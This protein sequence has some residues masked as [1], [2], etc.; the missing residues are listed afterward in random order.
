[1]NYFS[2]VDTDL[3]LKSS[4]IIHEMTTRDIAQRMAMSFEFAPSFL[5]IMDTLPDC[6]DTPKLRHWVSV[7]RSL[8]RSKLQTL[9]PDPRFVAHFFID[10]L[11]P[12]RVHEI[13][14]FR[15]L[16]IALE[17]AIHRGQDFEWHDETILCPPTFNVW[18]HGTA[19]SKQQFQGFKLTLAER[20]LQIGFGQ[21]EL[22]IDLDTRALEL[23]GEVAFQ[24]DLKA[25]TIVGDF[26]V[27][28]N[29]SGL[30]DTYHSNAPI[31]RGVEAN[32]EWASVFQQAVQ[33]LYN[34]SPAIAQDCLKLS[35]AVLALHT[36][37]TSFGSSSPQEAMGLIFLPGVDDAYDVAECLLHETLHQKL[38]RVEEGAPLFD[39]VRGDDEIYYSPWRS[40]AR[41]LRML[42]HGAYV[43]TGVS[44]LWKGIHASQ[45]NEIERD[46]AAFH[47]Y[48]RAQQAAAA[49][50]IVEKF[51]CRTDMGL[52]I[53]RIINDGIEDALDDLEVSASVM[54]EAFARLE[55]HRAKF[56]RHL[57]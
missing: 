16:E 21:C 29:V 32:K 57:Q 19:L 18:G 23:P 47:C 43:F 46:N 36:G 52:R 55:Q 20:Q 53:S 9:D 1:M 56:G 41:P 22:S 31:V 28:I 24:A 38:F 11:R 45:S 8:L 48:Y 27:P 34:Q 42:M 3:V 15:A 14:A 6:G 2:T 5:R 30:S 26:A 49:M 7:S 54:D 35:P 39:A 40:D 13:H 17:S 12:T 33:I 50:K 10:S 37:G 25:P 44:H 4:A 51:E